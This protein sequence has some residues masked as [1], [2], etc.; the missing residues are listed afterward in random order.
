VNAQL[1]ASACLLIAVACRAHSQPA[2]DPPVRIVS[3]TLIAQDAASRP[4]AT[5]RLTI[6]LAVMKDTGWSART[7]LDAARDATAILAQCGIQIELLEYVEFDGPRRYRSFSTP[8]AR[9]LA[10]QLGLRKPTVFFVADTLQRPAFDAEAIGRG[11]SRSRPELAD[12]IWIT[13]GTRDLEIVM[14]HELAH[15]LAD[16]GEHTTEPGNLMGEET[17]AERTRLN[18][19]QCGRIVTKAS[20]NGLLEPVR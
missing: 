1:L 3:R 7:V 5:H 11:N 2:A 10:S 20:A 12:T 15:V 13:S 18:T 14:A 16:S 8:V 19:A 9:E 17:S 4:A 6:T